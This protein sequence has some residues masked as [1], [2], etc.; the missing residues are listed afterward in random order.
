MRTIERATTQMLGAFSSGWSKKSPNFYLPLKW[1]KLFLAQFAL[2]TCPPPPPP[3]FFPPDFLSEPGAS[4]L[5]NCCW[6]ILSRGGGAQSNSR[7]GAFQEISFTVDCPKYP[8]PKKKNEVVGRYLFLLWLKVGAT[9]TVYIRLYFLGVT[10][11]K[12][13]TKYGLSE[14]D[15]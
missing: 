11:K 12:S 6:S 15:P 3:R 1:S 9:Y 7:R 8:P 14:R 13:D 10:S 5:W 4:C 2:S